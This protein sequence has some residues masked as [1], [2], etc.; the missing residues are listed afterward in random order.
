MLNRTPNHLFPANILQLLCHHLLQLLLLCTEHNMKYPQ[1]ER[2]GRD[3][4]LQT[5]KVKRSR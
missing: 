1:T 5:V 2:E 3:Q 4:P